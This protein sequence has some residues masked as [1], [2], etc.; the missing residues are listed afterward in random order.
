[1]DPSHLNP[2]VPILPD[3]GRTLLAPLRIAGAATLLGLVSVITLA[4]RSRPAERSDRARTTPVVLDVVAPPVVE[5]R[6]A[7]DRGTG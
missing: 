5:E 7:H 4:V 3:L 6:R 1:M 2:I